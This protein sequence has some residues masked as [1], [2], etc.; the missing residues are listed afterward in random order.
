[1]KRIICIL[2]A[3]VVAAAFLTACGSKGQRLDRID[4]GSVKH[5]TIATAANEEPQY[6]I[7]KR[8]GVVQLVDLYNS[9]VFN[10]TDEVTAEQLTAAPLYRFCFYDY[11]EKLIGACTITPDG[12]LFVGDDLTKPY[13]LAGG[14]D[15]EAIKEVITQ[16]NKPAVPA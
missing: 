1:M 9:A 2:L 15:E 7:P 11:D 3:A 8:K 13:K 14:F 6:D 5:V 16:Y 12:Y 4:T 10:E